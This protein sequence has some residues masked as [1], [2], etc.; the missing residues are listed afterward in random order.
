MY[1]FFQ[2]VQFNRL[3]C[4]KNI[5]HYFTS[6]HTHTHTHSSDLHLMI[7]PLVE[8]WEGLSRFGVSLF[9]KC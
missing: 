3:F 9:S 8:A 2:I 1:I 5:W 4:F 6:T 7:H